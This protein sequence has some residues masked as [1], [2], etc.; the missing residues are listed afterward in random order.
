MLKPPF[1]LRKQMKFNSTGKKKKGNKCP[2]ELSIV[3]PSPVSEFLVRLAI[4][5]WIRYVRFTA[6]GGKGFSLEGVPFIELYS[7]WTLW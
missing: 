1:C 2:V 6:Q 7:A 3:L 5:W 4:P